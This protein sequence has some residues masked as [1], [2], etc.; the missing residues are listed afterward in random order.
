MFLHKIYQLKAYSNFL[1]LEVAD[2]FHRE[3]LIAIYT[4]QFLYK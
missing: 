1:K 3:K 2:F 4:H